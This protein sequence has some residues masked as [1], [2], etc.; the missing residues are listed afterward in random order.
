MARRNLR[1][2]N[3]AEAAD[4]APVQDPVPVH[5]LPDIGVTSAPTSVVGQAVRLWIAPNDTAGDLARIA[6]RRL[7]VWRLRVTGLSPAEIAKRLDV[8]PAVVHADLTEQYAGRHERTAEYM[9]QCRHLEIAR[10]DAML[11]AW[12]TAGAGGLDVYAAPIVLRIT[13]LRNKLLG[14]DRL[15]AVVEDS[16][17][18]LSTLP[19]ADLLARLDAARRM[20]QAPDAAGPAPDT[21]PADLVA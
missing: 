8:S 18:P 6:D 11:A 9:E 5:G 21:P 13:E 12:W 1:R 15:P 17:R 3:R 20:L 7:E 16:A 2:L 19:A 4:P 10:L 14:L